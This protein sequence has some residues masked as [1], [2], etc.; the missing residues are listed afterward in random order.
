MPEMNPQHVQDQ[1]AGIN[2]FYSKVYGFLGLGIL[3]SGI[4]AYLS[5]QVFPAQVASF[6]QNFPLGI[7]GIWIVEIGLV[8]LLSAKAEKNPSLAIGGF[9]G[10][11]LINGI[12]LAITVSYYTNASVARAFITAAAMFIGLSIF[13]VVTKKDLSGIGRAAYSALI[14]III[15][16]L[17]N[18]FILNS[19]PVD[20][21][22][23]FLTIIIFSGITAYDNQMIRTLYVQSNGTVGNGVA[24]YMALS[25]YLDFINLFLALLRIFGKQN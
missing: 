2:K 15:A 25:L 12:V 23:S 4:V 5:M 8:I 24:V 16:I 11:S 21:L 1:T 19:Q 3:L 20:Y 18:A 6:I 14:G 10:Y 22:I 13:G 17:L 7:L 9:I